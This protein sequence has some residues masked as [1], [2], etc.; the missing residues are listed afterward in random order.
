[1]D[2]EREHS[3]RAEPPDE[4]HLRGLLELA[5][6]G[7]GGAGLPELLAPFARIA[8][9][10]LGFAAV[11][12]N[13]YRPDRDQYEV[14]AVHGKQAGADP[15]GGAC[16]AGIWA[17]RLD[18]RFLRRGTF[19][20]PATG[21]HDPGVHRETAWRPGDLLVVALDGSDGRRLGLI[22]IDE[23][24]SGRRPDDQLLDVV[25]AVAAQ[26]AQAIESA[27][28][29]SMLR[30]ALARHRAVIET[31]LDAVIALDRR[32]RI[33]EFNPAAQL[34]FGYR[35]DQA[36]GRNLAE[37]LVAPDDREACARGA[38]PRLRAARSHWPAP[39]D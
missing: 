1:M 25:G 17:R 28:Q 23:P 38:R 34:M 2:P 21:G 27:Y 19:L 5:R 12:I 33:I 39:E 10:T 18:P 15:V 31:S 26:A 20:I 36:I 6:L 22:S 4:G 29:L 9:E 37:L 11:T 7:R 30:G 32:G 14:A 35:C 8:A 16:P 24:H 3:G 13:V